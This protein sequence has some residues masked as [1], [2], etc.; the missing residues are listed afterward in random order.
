MS[1]KK[2]LLNIHVDRICIQ[3]ETHIWLKNFLSAETMPESAVTDI[4]Q[5]S[6]SMYSEVRCYAQ[7]LLFKIANRVV[8]E[9]HELILPMIAQCL[10]ADNPSVS[11]QQFKGAL[12]ILSMEK[13]G[14][15]YS[16]KNAALLFPALVQAQHSDKQSIADLLKDFSIKCNRS[17]TEFSLFSIPVY[18]PG[19]P[20]STLKELLG[21]EF[22]DSNEEMEVE[23]NMDEH[24]IELEKKLCQMVT[25]GNLHWRHY[26]MAI[27]ML[28]T[29]LGSEHKPGLETVQ[30]WLNCLLHDD[31]TIRFIA[32]QAVECILKLYKIKR[33][34]T[35]VDAPK[36]VIKHPGIRDDNAW[37]QYNSNLSDA[38]L[39]EYWS[40]GFTVKPELGFYT[41]SKSGKFTLRQVD[42]RI[43]K[44]P[45]FVS[46]AFLNFF[47]D[48]AKLEKFISL[49]CIEVKKGEDTFSMD[50]ALLYCSLIEAFGPCMVE[51][52]A[53]FALKFCA[54]SEESEQ[55]CASEMVFGMIKGSR[56]WSYE[57]CLGLWT[58]VL[59]PAFKTVLT[60]VN[61]D[62]LQDWEICL[63]GATNKHDANRL[64]WL[65]NLLIN[66][67]KG[68]KMSQ[69][70]A[71]AQ[72]SCLRLLN[73]SI[74]QNWKLREI[75][76]LS[77]DLLKP[78]TSHPYNKVRH[79]IS[80]IMA[81]VLSLD[82]R[83]GTSGNDLNMGKGYPTICDFIDFIKPKLSLNFHNPQLNGH[84]KQN[85]KMDII[86][87]NSN[88]V[89]EVDGNFSKEESS[90]EADN[91][92]ES[93]AL[94]VTQYIQCT[95]TSLRPEFYQL[96]PFF[97]QF[98]GNETGQEVSQTCL[99]ALCYLSVCITPPSSI[100]YVLEMIWK[101]AQSSSWKAKMSILEF[102]QTFVF[103][104][105][106]SL[107]LHRNL[108]QKI[109][110]LVIGMMQDETLQVRQ[111]A[112]KILSGLIHS[113]FIDLE[114]Q[115]RLIKE[116]RA[117]IRR[118]M[119]K[120]SNSK[121]KKA[122]KN[123]ANLSKAELATFHSGIL[124]LCAIVE[125]YPYD[126]PEMVPDILIELE[127]HLHDPLP[128][129]KTIKDCFQEFKR[130]HQ[131]NWQEHKLKFSDD[132][133]SV[134][135]DLLVSPNYYA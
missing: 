64:R 47:Q 72:A 3:H 77:F 86:E 106:M 40:K 67:V 18:P 89:M 83:Y 100:N 92:L 57:P 69:E 123:L 118:K 104:N 31:I 114:G 56:F 60:N 87:E 121:F 22:D 126:V 27:G 124:G 51:I 1:G 101:V 55:R 108:V 48:P 35:E 133:L 13:T 110:E 117:K 36:V 96:L 120:K 116:F 46:E 90:K 44:D 71:F 105:F 109:E 28:L 2:H 134:M 95:S 53:P 84:V 102:C 81:T 107:C 10:K 91:T 6:T 128:V 76:N 111:K 70:G 113:Q 115:A 62:T 85:G 29:L 42:D 73:K 112:T 21:T 38:D 5:L 94:W 119:Q 125:A 33:L 80:S 65:F 61:M 132:Q 25:S 82:I 79:Q 49:N 24:F 54:S 99:K 23:L 63:S 127:K 11:H 17:Y 43:L 7:E 19:L 88:S 78:Q 75:F 41:W 68:S 103:T 74:V 37:M 52:F 45:G 97:C 12:F 93:V 50:K 16:W 66:E 98:V 39:Q 59:I 4:F 34:R 131:D 8:P 32:F 130:T 14:F 129:P 26:Q 122:S 20:N 15:C 135:T 30:L 58:K 9:S